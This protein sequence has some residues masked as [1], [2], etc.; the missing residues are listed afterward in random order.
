M[1]LFTG[2]TFLLTLMSV[3]WLS[4]A[5]LSCISM[6]NQK[7]TV[8]PEIIDLNRNEPVFFSFSIKTG[9]CSGNCNNISNPYAKMCVADIVK[10][11]NVKLFNLMSR[12]NETRRTEWHETCHGRCRL[13]SS[14]CN[15]RQRWNDDKCMCEWK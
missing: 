8:W 3:N 11:L 4:T 5:P 10:N 12:T 1:F 13:D 6:N 9:K 7:C 15:N 2:L 14:I